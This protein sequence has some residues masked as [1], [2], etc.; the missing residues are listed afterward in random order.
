MIIDM[1]TFVDD[2][3]K[4]IKTE[5]LMFAPVPS[6]TITGALAPQDESP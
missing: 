5:I 6:D 4:A 2:F 3:L 1:R